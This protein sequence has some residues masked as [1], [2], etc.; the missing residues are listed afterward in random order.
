MNEEINAIH[1]ILP[2]ADSGGEY[3]YDIEDDTPGE[4]AQ[5][6]RWWI[7]SVLD[8]MIHYTAEHQRVLDVA[9]ATLELISP[10]DLV[11]NNVL[12]LLELPPH[13]FGVE[14]HEDLEFLM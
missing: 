12:P 4:K 9:A 11:M 1:Q 10:R 5:T 14:D 6:I 3:D 2:N 8:K 13:R 7:R